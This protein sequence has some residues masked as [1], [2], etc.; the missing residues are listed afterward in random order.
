M[1]PKKINNNQEELFKN[2]LSTQLKPNHEL[3][4]LA[5]KICWSV[6]EEE[7]GDLH[8]NSFKGGQP[9][10]PVR[11]MAGL[12]L[13]QYLH[14]LSDEAVI[15]GWL[16]N[17]Y[18]QY[19]CG[20]D[21]LQWEFPIDPSSLSRWRTRLGKTKI[22]KIL[23]LTVNVGVDLGVVSQKDFETVIV[24]TTVMPKNVAFPTD[25]RLLNKSRERMV[26]LAKKKGIKLRQNYNIVVKK[27]SRKIGGYLHAKQM[28]RA[29]A[30]IKKMR[31]CT[32]RVLRDIER[33]IK[34]NSLLQEAFACELEKA[35][36][37]LTQKRTSKNKLYS[38]HEPHVECIS[39]G[40]AH[41]RYEF[42]CKASFVI[43][44]GKGKGFVLSGEALHGNPYDGHTLQDTLA[45]SENITGIKAKKAFVD[46]GYKGHGVSDISI[47]LSRQKRGITPW[48]KKQLKRRQAI[49]P[50]FGHMKNEGKLNRC[51]LWD[52]I[53]DQV[54]AVMVAAGYN[55][56][57][58]L[59]YLRKVFAPIF[60]FIIL[61]DA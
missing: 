46:E 51:R 49:E 27:L 7:F 2:R 23:Q 26:K 11:L 8:K 16:E 5:D 39:K 32:G 14:N 50:Y 29:K 53:G 45:L 9:P 10:K 37:L 59:N 38:L 35:R 30:A 44:H 3:K 48:I 17:P 41:K 56:R 43:T 19:F 20:Y 18:W 36:R 57:L 58:I 28:K 25:S 13:L 12:L 54:H 34:G 47:F 42:G 55:L 1:E 21:Y 15:R 60:M 4:I 6:L 24:D 33:K 40:K 31:T 52:I 61:A 22:E